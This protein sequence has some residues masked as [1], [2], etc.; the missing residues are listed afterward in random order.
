MKLRRLGRL[1]IVAA[2]CGITAGLTASAAH[3]TSIGFDLD[4]EFSGATAPEGG[5]P[6]MRVTFDDATGNPNSVQLTIDALGLIGG[7]AGES[8]GSIY[9]NF[10]PALNPTLL[11]FNPIDN[12]ASTPTVINTGTNLF[13][14][15]GDGLFD[16]DFEMPPP[17][18]SPIDTRLTQ[19][20]VIVYELIY[21]SAI[22]ASSFDFMSEMGGG[23]GSYSAAAHI[24]SIGTS[25]ESGWIGPAAVPEPTTGVTLGVGLLVGLWFQRR[26]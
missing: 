17:P 12:S 21:P 6:W 26:S 20:E 7:Q 1:L 10:D 24:M 22:D 4:F 19:G 3:A 13:Q 23:Q 5:T 9:L 25:S 15:D 16:I 8:A 18:G 2:T 11:T 14:A